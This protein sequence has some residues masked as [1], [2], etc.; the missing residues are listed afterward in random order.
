MSVSTEI[1]NMRGNS[2]TVRDIELDLQELILP[3]NLLSNESLSLDDVPE[4][5]QLSPFKVDSWC[6]NC[7]QGVRICVLAS[8]GAIR[9]LEF[10]L[11]TSDL[12][13]L[14]PG[15]ARARVRHGRPYN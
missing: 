7:N 6:P 15:C 10:L 8:N 13:I 2:P 11:S 5:E 1:F 3:E 9:Q 12:S 4:E 14:C